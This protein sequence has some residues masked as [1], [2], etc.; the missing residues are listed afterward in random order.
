MQRVARK[1][2]LELEVGEEVER[3]LLDAHR[4]RCEEQLRIAHRENFE[5][6][7]RAP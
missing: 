3:Q 2:A 1:S 6:S 5:E 7:L 4:A